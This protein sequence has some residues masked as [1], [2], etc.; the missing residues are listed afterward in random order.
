MR[1]LESRL[2]AFKSAG[3]ML[4]DNGLTGFV[5]ADYTDDEI[6]HIFH[7]S[8]LTPDEI[9]KFRSAF[10]YETALL[11]SRHGFTAQYHVGAFRNANTSMFRRLGPDTGY[12][13]VD[14]A[15][16][17]RAFGAL[18]DKLNNAG[19]LPRTILYPIDINQYE[20]FAALAASFNGGRRGWVQLG[21]PWWFNDQYYGIMKQFESAGSL[22]PVSL[23]AGMLTDSRS[24]LSYPRHELYRRALCAYLGSIVDRGEYFSGG[25][26]LGEIIQNVCYRNIKE[27]LQLA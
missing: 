1:A 2:A 13:G 18:I 17:I 10:L 8:N 16:S 19:A 14:D 21:A 11:Y 26:A 12:D 23:S 24:F 27:Y 22:Y 7:K 25:E 5:W 6:D 9:N 3:A 20:A 4:N 15:A